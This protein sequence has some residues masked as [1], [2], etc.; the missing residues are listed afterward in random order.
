MNIKWLI[1]ICLK[2]NLL[3]R[4]HSSRMRTVR[5][6]GRLQ[7]VYLVTVP[8]PGGCTWYRGIGGV[9]GPGGTWYQGSG[10]V[11]G[12]QGVP[13]QVLTHEPRGYLVLGMGVY[14]VPGGT[15]PG[16][17]PMDL[18]SGGGGTCPGIPPIDLVSGGGGTCPG[19]FPMDLVSGVGYLP[20]YSPLW[21]DRHV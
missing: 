9:P 14:L 17:P 16:T 19:T 11:P 4:M 1:K 21:T 13:A 6:S 7:G 2:L 10:G 8:G 15:C 3:T 12:P 18:V 5:N 20:R